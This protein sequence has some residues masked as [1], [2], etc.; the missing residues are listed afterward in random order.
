MM[1]T[2]TVLRFYRGRVRCTMYDVNVYK[3]GVHTIL[4]SRELT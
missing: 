2:P 1:W 3:A 4:T